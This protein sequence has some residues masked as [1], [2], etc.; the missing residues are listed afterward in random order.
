MKFS[1]LLTVSTALL[2]GAASVFAGGQGEQKAS[3]GPIYLNLWHIHT[4]DT[5]ASRSRTR[6]PF[7]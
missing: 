3:S 6:P 4:Q 1:K 7:R 5:R 2:I